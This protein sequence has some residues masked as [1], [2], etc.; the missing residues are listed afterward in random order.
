[1]K[2]NYLK[3]HLCIALAAVMVCSAA[4][5][6]MAEDLL[7][8]EPAEVVVT[9]T[10]VPVQPE[11]VPETPAPVQPA[12]EIPATPVPETPVPA[13]PVPETPVPEAPQ[14][15][16]APEPTAVPAETTEEPQ[17]PTA[18]PL[19]PTNVPE[20]EEL[21]DL[22]P[23]VTDEPTQGAEDPAADP[24]H[25]STP[26]PEPTATNTPSPEPTATNTPTPT[27]LPEKVKWIIDEIDKLIALPEIT[28]EQ[29]DKIEKIRK[30]YDQLS[31]EDKK[32]IKNYKDFVSIEEKLNK[33]IKEEEEK[34]KEKNRI[35]FYISNIRAGKE[36]YISSLQSKY[37]LT[38]SKDLGNVMDQIE[39]EY[40][41]ANGI[42][43]EG[44]SAGTLTS[45][46][47]TLLVRNWQ[48]IL[49]VYVYGQ[50]KQGKESFTIDAS[51]KEELA[52]IFAE[53]N[54]VV[55]NNINISKFSYGNRHIDYYI[56]NHKLSQ[57]DREFLSRYVETDCKLLC[58][59]T[60]AAKGFVRQS[61]GE[62]VSEE[63]VNVITAAYSLIGQVGYFWGGKSDV[64][65]S[66]SR[67]G[68][69]AVVMAEG[70]HTTGT[71][72]AYGL[73]CS[74]FVS[75]SVINGYHSLG[76]LAYIGHGTSSQWFH[77]NTISA[78]AAQ[79]G[80]LVFAKGPENGSDNH[81]GI[82]C[83]QTDGGDWLA[84]HCTA[85]RNGI[86]V[87]EAYS[88]GFRY[89][90]QLAVFPTEEQVKAMILDEL[91]DGQAVDTE[92]TGESISVSGTGYLDVLISDG[93][94]TLSSGEDDTVIIDDS[95]VEPF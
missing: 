26:S 91:S 59:V 1:M 47:D 23:S 42:L 39:A 27:P 41:E 21:S 66:D 40:K 60:T 86:T 12:P 14:E 53:M 7:T 11:V 78:D 38:L 20:A 49:A 17:E 55:R 3:K 75:W 37:H 67:W 29:K 18:A 9:D 93:V 25:T 45:S 79:P 22:S 73:D 52:E 2:Y 48:D 76:M 68:S 24:T 51:A 84:V 36:F 81:V 58:A 8:S 33:L 65:G 88:A 32:L 62:S 71:G 85:S 16:V 56:R 69:P 61:V 15:T 94:G 77:A 74:G 10:P 63:R 82:L 95:E 5:P 70:S 87:G 35:S 34:E 92:G 57:E 28:L 46:R 50:H 89:I 31:G 64:I 4:A 80:D 90:R 19:V 43:K 6:V 13:T 83:G 44:E 30:E 54:P 72:R